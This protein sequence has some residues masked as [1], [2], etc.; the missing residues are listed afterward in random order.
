MTGDGLPD[1][2]LEWVRSGSDYFARRLAE[3]TEEDVAGDSL[4]PGW[5]R[6][7]VIAHVGYNAVALRRLCHWARTGEETPMY[8]SEEARDA[9]IARGAALPLG[10]LRQLCTDSRDALDDDWRSLPAEAWEAEVRTRQGRRLR[11]RETV[12]MRAREVWIHGVDLATGGSYRDFPPAVVDRL[13]ADVLEGWAARGEAV[14]MVL[15]PTDRDGP[16]SI[17]S[18]GPTVSGSAA[19]LARWLTGRGGGGLESS[20]GEL[21]ALPRW[22]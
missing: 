18:P 11:A 20:T 8:T 10:E 14:D 3:L 19:D 12:W 2:D 17:G 7:A 15:H 22:L 1:E 5:T 6:G 9:E 21:P 13:T 16:T 4:L